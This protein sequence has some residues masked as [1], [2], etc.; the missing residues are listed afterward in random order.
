MNKKIKQEKQEKEKKTDSKGRR[1]R[2]F[3]IVQFLQNNQTR[4][5]LLDVEK[6]HKM[7]A[8]SKK[9]SK[10]AFILHDKDCLTYFQGGECK[11]YKDELGNKVK[12]EKHIHCYIAF[13]NACTVKS[14]SKALRIPENL[15]KVVNGGKKAETEIIRYFL[16]KTKEA[17][18]ALKHEY[19]E[20]EIVANFD[21]VTNERKELT[22]EEVFDNLV[23]ELGAMY[24]KAANDGSMSFA[25][26]DNELRGERFIKHLNFE[27]VLEELMNGTELSEEEMIEKL[28]H[29]VWTNWCKKIE[30]GEKNFT[31]NFDKY[32][33]K[34]TILICGLGGTGKTTLAKEIAMLETSWNE[35]KAFRVGGRGTF[36]DGLTPRHDVIT[37]DD[38]RSY[39]ILEGLGGRGTMLTFFD[40]HPT[41]TQKFNIKYSSVTPYF[42][43]AL[44]TTV[45]VPCQF[46]NGLAGTFV[47]KTGSF[48][49]AEDSGQIYR[50]FSKIVR[51]SKRKLEI[52]ISAD[53]ANAVAD[54]DL[55]GKKRD[56]KKR[57]ELLEFY[58]FTF[59]NYYDL[60]EAIERKKEKQ[61]CDITVIQDLLK[62]SEEEF[63][64][65]Y[66]KYDK[67]NGNWEYIRFDASFVSN[68]DDDDNENGEYKV[69]YKVQ[70]LDGEEIIFYG[71]DDEAFPF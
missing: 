55:Y 21:F 62:F 19:D 32:R 29:K 56:E 9:V 15:I 18:K 46:L 42:K 67:K 14:I 57:E 60:T 40:P 50:R 8:M 64:K 36:L 5:K 17:K 13:K 6:F 33:D 47:D 16:H 1:Y 12:K 35:S 10:Y 51:I 68:D 27:N 69:K 30:Q 66:K 45:E 2:N 71:E 38:K 23:D 44:V 7:L 41:E 31:K 4:E 34:Q 70:H 61:K 3:K 43:L 65:K 26:V 52:Y 20:S 28:R 22:T 24:F 37:F 59:K 48:R 58:K 49:E 63:V 54:L 11:Y 39:E 25:D 53:R